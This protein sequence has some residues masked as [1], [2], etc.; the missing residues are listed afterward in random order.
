MAA[1]GRRYQFLCDGLV[2]TETSFQTERIEKNGAPAAT[3]T[4]D[5]RLRRGAVCD[6]GA[7]L[8]SRLRGLPR[9]C[10]TRLMCATSP[11]MC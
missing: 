2:F 7:F 1:D 4:R 5:P 6:R 9:G 8:F 11:R 3:R 10:A